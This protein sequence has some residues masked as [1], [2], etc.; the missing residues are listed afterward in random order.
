MIVAI[1]S[2]DSDFTIT[3]I[4]KGDVKCATAKINDN[5]VLLTIELL[6]FGAVCKRCSCWFIDNSLDIEASHFS[7][8]NCCL[9]LSV[10]EVR[11]HR[12]DCIL[13]LYSVPFLLLVVSLR[14]FL[15]LLE[16]EA[17]DI[18]WSVQFLLAFLIHSKQRILID[19]TLKPERPQLYVVLDASVG[20][21]LADEA[22]RIKN[23]VF[24]V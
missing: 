12:D 16:E 21:F 5:D 22:L 19:V 17:R 20:E 7:G 18:F 1:G 24:S 3:Y 9:P 2:Q 6:G 23:R 15:H 8:F 11:R 4:D 13:D 14:I 10:I